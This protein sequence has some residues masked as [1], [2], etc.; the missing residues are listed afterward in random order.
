MR[1]KESWSARAA[2]R[3]ESPKARSAIVD[4]S[5]VV[6]QAPRGMVRILLEEVDVSSLAAAQ[7]P[8]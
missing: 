1:D 8:A 6:P 3:F 2:E 7:P 4:D 5:K